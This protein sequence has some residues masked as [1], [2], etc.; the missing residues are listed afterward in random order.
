MKNKMKIMGAIF[1]L[2]VLFISACS[3]DNGPVTNNDKLS[4]FSSGQ[5]LVDAFKDAQV[6]NYGGGIFRGDG[7]LM[8]A[9]AE[10]ATAN[11]KASDSGDYSETNVQVQGVDEADIIKTDGNYIY[12]IENNK[13]MI[14]KAYPEEDAEILY[15]EELD[16][17]Y[18]NEL[19]IEGSKLLVFGVENY[20]TLTKEIDGPMGP[21]Q[22]ADDVAIDSGL[23]MPYYGSFM[24]VKLYD[25]SDKQNPELIKDVDFE[26][27]YLTS[28]KI[29]NYV[30]F[31]VNSYPRVYAENYGCLDIVPLYREAFYEEVTSD[32]FKPIANC[33][34]I[35]YIMP[36]QARS[37]I[38]IAGIDM[39]NGD[40][41]KETIVGSGEDVYAS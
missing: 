1:V 9:Q 26:G 2:A 32:E 7:V 20:N 23:I 29:D 12:A 22:V 30:Y 27:N 31:V 37:F 38:T 41:N 19:F 8:A 28:R 18:P 17:F 35:G 11:G 15:E 6:N 39:D 25:I 16:N 24:S 21:K 4:R 5:E 40:V 13:L 10:T 33:V 34:D 14:A 3:I 36:I